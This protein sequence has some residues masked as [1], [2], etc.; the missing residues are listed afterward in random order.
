MIS[1]TKIFYYVEISICDKIDKKSLPSGL[2]QL[3]K[4]KTKLI[5]TFF[6]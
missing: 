4:T 6:S 5:K 3:T 2:L 1:S